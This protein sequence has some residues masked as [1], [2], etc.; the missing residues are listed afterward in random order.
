MGSFFENEPILE[1][2][3]EAWRSFYDRIGVC[4]GAA[5]LPKTTPAPQ[6]ALH[7][8]A[9]TTERRY[10]AAHSMTDKARNLV[11]PGEGFEV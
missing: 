6:S 9:A 5:E 11:C 7:R 1:G 10:N 2:V 8:S 4:E 3:L